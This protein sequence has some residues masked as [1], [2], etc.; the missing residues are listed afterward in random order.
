MPPHVCAGAVLEGALEGI[1]AGVAEGV[2][3]F[4]SCCKMCTRA[5]DCESFTHLSDRHH[6]LMYKTSTGHHQENSLARS[7]SVHSWP[8]PPPLPSPVPSPPPPSPKPPPPP[9]VEVT[10]TSVA[11]PGS[12][13]FTAELSGFDLS[14]GGLALPPL[15]T[16]PVATARCVALGHSCGGVTALGHPAEQGRYSVR[17]GTELQPS[18]TGGSAWLKLCDD[19]KCEVEHGVWYWGSHLRTLSHT[20]DV[21]ACCDACL[22]TRDCVSFNLG[23]GSCALY[24]SRAERHDDRGFVSGRVHRPASPPPPPLPPPPLPRSPPAPPPPPPSPSPPPQSPPHPPH[25]PHPEPPPPSGPP[26]SPPPPPAPPPP[27]EDG[28]RPG[29][30]Y[31][32]SASCSALAAGWEE[33][34]QVNRVLEYALFYASTEALRA[35]AERTQGPRPATHAT[36]DQ[37]APRLLQTAGSLTGLAAGTNYSIVARAK[38]AEGWG[39]PSEPLQARQR[40]T[41][42][43]TCHPL[44]V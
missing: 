41:L 16:L 24:S 14:T 35:G 33:A 37:H 32:L 12:C 9:S 1:L 23:A 42:V 21:D 8:L 4:S 43:R 26:P 22:A 10:F 28:L 30:P 31:L 13:R 44:T 18:P 25:P 15:A 39:P 38:T 6:C 5:P 40:L 34:A 3:D 2:H 20:L 19:S 27:P 17:G 7:G 11:P 36:A 29:R